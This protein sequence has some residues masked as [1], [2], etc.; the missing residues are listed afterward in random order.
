MLLVRYALSSNFLTWSTKRRGIFIFEVKTTTQAHSGKFF[1]LCL[2]MK[3]IRAK[4]AKVYFAYSTQRDQHGII[5][6]G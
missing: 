1:I 3:T 4:Q 5:A 2:S 6:Q